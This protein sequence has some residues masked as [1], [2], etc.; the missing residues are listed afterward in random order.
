MSAR[1]EPSC[2]SLTKTMQLGEQPEGVKATPDGKL[3]YVTSEETG[4]ISVLDPA[5]GKILKTFKVGHR[6]RSVAFLP[7]GS[8][9]YINAENDGTVIVV[10]A[11]KQKM[12]DSDDTSGQGW[13]DQAD[14]SVACAGRNQAL[15]EHRPRPYGVHDRHHYRQGRQVGRS[16]A[17]PVG[18]CALKAGG[19]PWGVIVLER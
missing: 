14:G 11:V 19:S 15:R 18:N 17:A 16:G 4:T 6:P 3:V 13:R 5:A 12:I 9:A 2:S 1:M 7:D 8:K 10:D